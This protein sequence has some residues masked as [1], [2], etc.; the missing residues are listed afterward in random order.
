MKLTFTSRLQNYAVHHV[1]LPTGKSYQGSLLI[2]F[3]RDCHL[4]TDKRGLGLINSILRLTFA[5]NS[6]SKSAR[7]LA[8]SGVNDMTIIDVE[9]RNRCCESVSLISLANCLTCSH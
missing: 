9:I 7:N 1:W 2:H 6:T 5:I 8:V 3:D 4:V